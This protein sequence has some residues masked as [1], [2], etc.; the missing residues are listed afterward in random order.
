L[1][2]VY[3]FKIQGEAQSTEEF[4][5]MLRDQVGLVLTPTQRSIEVTVVRPVE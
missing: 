1:S 4:L 3:D 5:G 2:G